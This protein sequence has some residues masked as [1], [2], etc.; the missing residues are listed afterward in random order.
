MFP[1]GGGRVERE[2]ECAT[3]NHTGTSEKAVERTSVCR[4]FKQF[5]PY[6]ILE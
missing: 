6:D 2:F 3:T 5:V 4:T 1:L